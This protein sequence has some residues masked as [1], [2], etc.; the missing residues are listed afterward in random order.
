MLNP[1]KSHPL[2]FSGAIFKVPPPLFKDN[3][4]RPPHLSTPPP[5]PPVL[6][7]LR[8]GEGEW[9]GVGGGGGGIVDNINLINCKNMFCIICN[10]NI[11]S[12][13]CGLKL[14]D[15]FF[16]FIAEIE[17]GNWLHLKDA[18][19]TVP[20]DGFDALICMGNSFAHLPDFDGNQTGHYTAIQ[21]FYNFLRPGGILIIDHRNYDH[22]VRGGKA[23]MKNIYYK[24]GLPITIVI[25]CILFFIHTFCL[26]QVNEHCRDANPDLYY[27][28]EMTRQQ[29]PN[30]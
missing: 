9:G 10:L 4:H 28:A 12:L 3:C 27:C 13:H 7:G 15:Y 6:R 11:S 18:A 30:I 2:L 26:P 19:I 24:V 23:P 8:W 20:D 16:P 14:V 21:N 25:T 22:I 17:E 5:I 29:N 1:E